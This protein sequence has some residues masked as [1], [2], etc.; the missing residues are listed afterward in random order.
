M[1]AMLDPNFHRTV[2]YIC[3]HSEQGA[4]GLIVN[5]PLDMDFGEVMEQ[6]E[7]Q[8]SEPGIAT[9]PVLQGGPVELQRGF[10][11]HERPHEWDSTVEVTDSIFV[12]T[13]R[14]ILGAMAARQRPAQ[15]TAGARLRGLG[16]WPAGTGN[17]G[18]RLAERTCRGAVVVRRALRAA[19]RRQRSRCSASIWA[20][21]APRPGMPDGRW[22]LA[23]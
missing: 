20:H 18:Q 22:L 9:Q 19:L 1:P 14:D 12:T 23:R 2:T 13:S 16:T 7:L 4:L 10:V 8:P 11:I 15:C 5:R 17:S 6:L 3:E 21:S